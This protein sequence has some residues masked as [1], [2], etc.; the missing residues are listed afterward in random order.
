VSKAV[1]SAQTSE[2]AAQFVRYLETG[3]PT[4]GL[5]TARVFCDFTLPRWR[6]Q[7]QGVDP[8]LALRKQGHPCPGKVPR[9]RVDPTPT[10][11][12]LEVE[13]EWSAGGEDWYCREIFRADLVDGAI[14][15]LSV[16]CT[17]DWDT[18]RRAQHAREVQLPRP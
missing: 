10:G 14:D 3:E 2:I 7:A 9:Y 15:S 13:E 8:V 17:G 16:Y 18:S 6:L 12:V 11:F 1:A 4:P 5:F